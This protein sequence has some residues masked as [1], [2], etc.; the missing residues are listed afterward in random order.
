MALSSPAVSQMD[1]RIW[2]DANVWDPY[3]WSDPNGVAAKEY[4]EYTE[5]NVEKVD[6]GFGAVSKGTDRLVFC[7]FSLDVSFLTS[8]CSSYLPFGA[9]RHR[10]IGE[11]VRRTTFLSFS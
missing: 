8:R 7:L 3:R 11:Q 5:G 10:C 9:G 1:P 4:K 2:K 6:F